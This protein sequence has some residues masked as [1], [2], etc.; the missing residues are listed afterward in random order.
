MNMMYECDVRIWCMNVMYNMM[1]IIKM[2]SRWECDVHTCICVRI[3][4]FM[5]KNILVDVQKLSNVRQPGNQIILSNYL[6]LSEILKLI[7]FIKFLLYNKIKKWKVQKCIRFY[8]HNFK[9]F[10]F[11]LELWYT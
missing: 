2:Q 11:V 9:S 1:F 4:V 3:Y 6:L 10:K 7:R 8:T 5:Y